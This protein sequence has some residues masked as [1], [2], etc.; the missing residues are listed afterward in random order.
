MDWLWTWSGKCFGYRDVDDLWTYNGRHIGH[1]SGDEVYGPDGLYI[2]ELM[3]DRLI[4]NLAKRSW[5]GPAFTPY[6][7]RASYAK[8]INYVGYSMCAGH[9]DFPGPEKFN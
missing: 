6:G 9:E 1:F 4:T 7:R 8:Y 3:N 2:G 5:R